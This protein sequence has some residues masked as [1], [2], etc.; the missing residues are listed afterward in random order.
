MTILAQKRTSKLIRVN[1]VVENRIS[2]SRTIICSLS[3]AEI[4]YINAIIAVACNSVDDT[5]KFA[6]NSFERSC[7]A[8][9]KNEKRERTNAKN[10]H[11][12]KR[13]IVF[14]RLNKKKLCTGTFA[15]CGWA[16]AMLLSLLFF[17][18]CNSCCCCCF[19]CCCCCST[20]RSDG[21]QAN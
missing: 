7:I 6:F 20:E 8:S 2:T 21:V 19:Y 14:F 13:W 12:T 16:A 5:V 9:K 15:L 1:Q 11:R 3:Y 10:I 17:R 4:L 18:C